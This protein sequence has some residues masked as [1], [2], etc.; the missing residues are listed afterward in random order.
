MIELAF[1]HTLTLERFIKNNYDGT[2]VYE[3]AQTV[4][5][6]KEDKL[7][8]VISS[9]GEQV[10]SKSSYYTTKKIGEHDKIDGNPILTIEHLNMLG[11][12]Y[13]RSYV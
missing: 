5:C 3:P 7:T 9:T 11:E 1:V 2:V 4:K 8:K 6:Y 12:S 13:Y 10:T